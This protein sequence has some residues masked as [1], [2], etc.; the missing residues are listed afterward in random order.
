MLYRDQLYSHGKTGVSLAQRKQTA[1]KI[2]LS[3]TIVVI[4]DQPIKQLLSSSEISRRM[5]K[6]KFELEGYDIQY[7][8]RT[9]IKGQILADFIVER[10]EEESPDKLMTEPEELLEPWTLFTNGLF[11]IDGSEAGLILTNPEGAEFTYAMRFRFEATNN[12]AEYE[13][14]IA[15][16][17]IAEQIGIKALQ[18]HVDSRIRH[19]PIF[20]QSKNARKKLQGIFHQASTTEQKQES[21]CPKQDYIHKLPTSQQTGACGRTE[22][23][24]ILPADKKKAI[25]VRRKAARVFKDLPVSRISRPPNWPIKVVLG[26]GFDEVVKDYKVLRIVYYGFSLSQVEVYSLGTDSWREVKT[27]VKFLVFESGSSVFLN[28]ALHWTALGFEEMNGKKLVVG[29]GLREEVFKYI[30]P[31]NFDVGGE[32]FSWNVVAVKD[33]LGVIVSTKS[34]T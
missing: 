4:T 25:A 19:D 26:F 5:L 22:G 10:P 8:P 21:I 3:T 7:R 16:L 34:G 31:P 32:K 30:M 27:S 1:E 15:G 28:G 17:R 6:W 14:L 23:E 20:E 29:F 9:A 11:C 2:F 13:A 12:E 24:E 33:L 18:A